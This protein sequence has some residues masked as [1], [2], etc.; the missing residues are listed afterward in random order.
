MALAKRDS[1]DRLVSK[2]MNDGHVSDAEFQIISAELSQYHILKER[3]R[4]KLT[5][6][7]SKQHV[8]SVD[9]E[10]IKD[11]GRKQGRREAESEYAEL[12]EFRKKLI[13]REERKHV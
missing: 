13:S 2:A 10:K 7:P 5:R 9:G 1:V 8:D 4:A 6:K 12:A 3:A 11:E